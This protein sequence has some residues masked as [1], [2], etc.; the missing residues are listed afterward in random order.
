MSWGGAGIGAAIGTIFGGPLGAGVGAAIGHFISE[1]SRENNQKIIICPHCGTELNIDNEGIIWRCP[2]CN[3]F[4]IALENLEDDEEYLIYTYLCTFGLIAKIAKIDG[5]VSKQEA[6]T[7]NSILD[8]FTANLEERELAKNFYNEAK[9]N[10]NPL[11]YYGELLYSIS[12]KDEELRNMIYGALFEV[13]AADGGLETIEKNALMNLLDILHINRNFY[14]YL[15]DELVGN[16]KSIKEYF[17]ILGCDENA[18]NA[19]IKKAYRQKVKEFH[20]DTIMGKN[21]P[22]SFIKF[23]NEQMRLITESYEEI[24]KYRG[25]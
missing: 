8:R 18:T 22:E 5:V 13:A 20:P 24:R 2:N 19:E 14:D 16:R 15:Y 25:F 6:S 3:K 1:S 21:L 4:F 7:I 23:A 12:F 17:E 9:N 10:N 11:E